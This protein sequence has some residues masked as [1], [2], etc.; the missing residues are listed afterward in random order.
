MITKRTAIAPGYAPPAP[1]LTIRMAGSEL[2]IDVLTGLHVIVAPGRSVRPDTFRTETAPL[3]PTVD[4]CPFCAGNETETPPEVARRGDGA[5]DTPG[6]T[7]RVVPN[8][9]PIVGSRGS[10]P[11]DTGDG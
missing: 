9:Y 10:E 5:A 4:S 8:K 6:W 1:S 7:I 3:P 2:R 11:G